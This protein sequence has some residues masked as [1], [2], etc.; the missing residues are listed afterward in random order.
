MVPNIERRDFLKGVGVTG[1]A[2]LAGCIEGVT[3]QGGSDGPDVLNVI[4]YPESGNQLFRDYY[5]MDADVDVIVPDGLLDPNLPDQVGNSMEDV[6]GTAPAAAGPNRDAFTEL[7]R[8]EYDEAPGVFTSHAFDSS[9]IQILANAAAGE[10]SGEA[11]RDQ[12]RRVANG[13]GTEYGPADFVDAVE[14]AANG[15]D[16]NYQGASSVVDFDERGDPASAA[17]DIW[18]FDDS[19]EGSEVLDTIDF[20]GNAGGDM[21]DS[22]PGGTDRTIK[23]GILQALT[24]DLGPV[25]EPIANAAEIPAK[26]ANESDLGL[27]VDTQVE[28]TQ[29]DRAAAISGAETLVNAGYPMVNGTLSS[30]NNVPVSKEVFIPNGVVGCSP[31]STALSV[32]F[33]DDDGFIF[34]TAPSDLL[35]GQVM[36]QVAAERLDGGTSSTLYV[37]NDYG[38]QL[39]DQYAETFMEEHGGEIYH[40]VAFNKGESSYTSVIEQALSGPDE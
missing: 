35:Q 22:S 9:A 17:Y 10:N 36:A 11:I 30:G 23:L 21:A 4:G 33:L 8:D 26:M 6:T 19:E 34:R 24:G 1:V 16:I 29:T 3:D 5:S 25:G 27:E 38:Q 12:M 37:N 20:E 2:G 28:D 31:S 32:S 7:Y 40:K 39:S 18:Q 13:P 15:E 14:A